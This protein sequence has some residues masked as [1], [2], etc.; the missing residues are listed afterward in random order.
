MLGREYLSINQDCRNQD[1][2]AIIVVFRNIALRYRFYS[3]DLVGIIIKIRILRLLR[4]I[5]KD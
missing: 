5:H 4:L 2:G 1:R 3:L